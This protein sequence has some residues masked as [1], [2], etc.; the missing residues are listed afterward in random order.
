MRK[1][2][3]TLYVFAEFSKAF[4]TV[5]QLHNL[6]FRI[7]YLVQ[8]NEKTSKRLLREFGESILGPVYVSQLRNNGPSSYLQY[9]IYIITTLEGKRISLTGLPRITSS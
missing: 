6:G 4:D 9:I 8:V 5:K 2:G 3:V 7:V 1:G